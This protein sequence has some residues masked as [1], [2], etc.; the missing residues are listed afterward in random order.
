MAPNGKSRHG[1][2]PAALRAGQA[3]RA[4]VV[5]IGMLGGGL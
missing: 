2:L 5:L 4:A 3:R 1:V